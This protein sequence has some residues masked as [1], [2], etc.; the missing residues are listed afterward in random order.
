MSLKSFHNHLHWHTTEIHEYHG[1]LVIEL[2]FYFSHPQLGPALY[3]LL[4]PTPTKA[5]KDIEDPE[6]E[7]STSKAEKG[8]LKSGPSP[9]HQETIVTWADVDVDFMDYYPRMCYGGV[10][11]MQ[12]LYYI[13]F[14]PFSTHLSLNWHFSPEAPVVEV[15]ETDQGDF[16]ELKQVV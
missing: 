12:L 3:S 10:S 6:F 4:N 16:V 5:P 9:P 14:F 7:T 13:L 1:F 11:E 15:E 8:S 2:S